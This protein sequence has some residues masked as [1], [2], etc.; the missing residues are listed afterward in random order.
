MDRK[1]D[2]ATD[3]SAMTANVDAE[4]GDV[5][6]AISQQKKKPEVK[7][8]NVAAATDIIGD[9]P[10]LTSPQ[11]RTHMKSRRSPAIV[12]GEDIVLENVTTRLRRETNELLTEAALRQRLKKTNPASRQDIVEAALREWFKK[13]G[14]TS[15]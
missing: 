6:R 13:H 12:S 11:P 5:L 10:A 2:F 9:D 1:P 15:E 14:Y 3:L 7:V 4:V 8:V